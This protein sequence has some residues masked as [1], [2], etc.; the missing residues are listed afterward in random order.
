MKQL[1]LNS[2]VFAL[3]DTTISHF[4]QGIDTES[5]VKNY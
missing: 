1:A 4:V 5:F 2:Q 3:I